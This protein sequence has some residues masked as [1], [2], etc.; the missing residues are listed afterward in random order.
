M[1][2]AGELTGDENAIEVKN[3]DLLFKPYKSTTL[4]LR[5]GKIR[6]EI[7]RHAQPAAAPFV[8][9]TTEGEEVSAQ[10][11]L[12]N[13][14]PKEDFVP[15]DHIEASDNTRRGEFKPIWLLSE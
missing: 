10:P 15:D 14:E 9:R 4:R 8:T 7:L 1:F 11:R 2:R 5:Y 3:M 12:G 13:T 6:N